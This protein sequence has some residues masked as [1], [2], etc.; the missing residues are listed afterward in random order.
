MS[1][2]LRGPRTEQFPAECGNGQDP[3]YC[4]RFAEATDGVSPPGV[5]LSI[6]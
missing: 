2:F 3:A 4:G 1:V 5:F 6:S